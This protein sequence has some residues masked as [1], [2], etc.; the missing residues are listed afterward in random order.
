MID[1]ASDF[2]TLIFK[3]YFVDINLFM[4]LLFLLSFMPAFKDQGKWLI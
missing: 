4:I 2:V 3:R 1:I